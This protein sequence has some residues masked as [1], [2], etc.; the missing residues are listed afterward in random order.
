MKVFVVMR[1]CVVGLSSIRTISK[2]IYTVLSYVPS[3]ILPGTSA[4]PIAAERK[5]SQPQVFS[6]GRR[7]PHRYCDE[8]F[9]KAASPY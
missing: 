6:P 7:Q 1:L 2:Y 4:T 5:Q 3:L 8:V 9:G